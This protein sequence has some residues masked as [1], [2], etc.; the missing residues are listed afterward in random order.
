MT[1]AAPL[2]IHPF[3]AALR[4]TPCAMA[5]VSP[6]FTAARPTLHRLS[7]L[8]GAPP[9]RGAAA[10]RRRAATMAASTLADLGSVADIDGGE[11]PLAGRPAFVV[12]VASEC[13]YTASGY[14]MMKD[15]LAKYGEKVAVVA[16][17][18]NAFGMY[19]FLHPI[20]VC[21][22]AGVLAVSSGRR[23]TPPVLHFLSCRR[24]HCAPVR[25]WQRPADLPG[26]HP[27][28]RLGFPPFCTARACRQEPGSAE[29]IKSF[30]AA[31]AL[32]VLIAP[33]SAVNGSESHPLFAVGKGAFPGDCGW[34]FAC[35]CA[36]GAPCD[37]ARAQTHC[38]DASLHPQCPVPLRFL[39]RTACPGS[40]FSWGRARRER[41]GGRGIVSVG[42]R[43]P[44][45]VD[46]HLTGPIPRLLPPTPR[47]PHAF[48][49]TLIFWPPLH[50]LFSIFVPF[51]SQSCTTRAAS[52]WLALT[53]PP[54]SPTS[55]LPLTRCSKE[56]MQGSQRRPPVSGEG[57]RWGAPVPCTQPL[58]TPPN[59]QHKH[60]GADCGTRFG[61]YSGAHAEG[62]GG[63]TPR[64]GHPCPRRPCPR[65]PQPPCPA[66]RSG[67]AGSG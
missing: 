14:Q 67:T 27:S 47:P 25:R 52:L 43:C 31:R 16:V 40:C 23:F 56:R 28:L 18:C 64:G 42:A 1:R 50:S 37:S 58:S 49:S 35:R 62:G 19:V 33:K 32:G 26:F 29:Q 3:S 41:E 51:P 22:G 57:A 48:S 59:P 4:P 11:L 13:G 10:P 44:Y 66:P 55:P 54:R 53:T 8:R 6:A 46:A 15:L 60:K 30:V 12:N 65:R 9:A 2:D 5:F 7:A 20:A 45:S 38:A 36:L 34:N 17:P 21:H 39:L 63:G 61:M 24:F